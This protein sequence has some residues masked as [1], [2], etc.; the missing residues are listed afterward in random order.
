MTKGPIEKYAASTDALLAQAC[1]YPSFVRFFCSLALATVTRWKARRFLL[2][3]KKTVVRS[4]SICLVTGLV[5]PNSFRDAFDRLF[6]IETVQT[7]LMNGEIS[8]IRLKMLEKSIQ[9]AFEARSD[10]ILSIHSKLQ[11]ISRT[12][13][14]NGNQ[15]CDVASVLILVGGRLIDTTKN[16]KEL[17]KKLWPCLGKNDAVMPRLEIAGIYR[18]AAVH[19]IDRHL[20]KRVEYNEQ[21]EATN[22]S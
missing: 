3:P 2:K 21:D 14:T 13:H 5:A 9:S 18:P 17:D 20:I 12:L 16:T 11:T 1:A 10:A 19:R 22:P 8:G 15:R 4:L 6:V 7:W